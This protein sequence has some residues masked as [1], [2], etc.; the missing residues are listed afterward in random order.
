MCG[1]VA[2]RG[3]RD[4]A[5]KSRCTRGWWEAAVWCR[6]WREHAGVVCAHGSVVRRDGRLCA[7]SFNEMLL[8][9]ELRL[10]L[11]KLRRK[12]FMIG[13]VFKERQSVVER[14]SQFFWRK[15]KR[16]SYT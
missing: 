12:N 2:E 10:H 9:G 14:G 13:C 7:E 3:E 5:V 16:G 1:V 11:V 15:K 8:G 4:A 6:V